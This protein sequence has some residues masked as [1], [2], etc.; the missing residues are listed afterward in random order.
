MRNVMANLL[1]AHY[2]KF[3][4]SLQEASVNYKWISIKIGDFFAAH[5]THIS[6]I[7]DRGNLYSFME[8][9]FVVLNGVEN[10]IQIWDIVMIFC[11]TVNILIL[12]SNGTVNI[13]FA[14]YREYNVSKEN[15]KLSEEMLVF[16]FVSAELVSV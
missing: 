10:Y 14:W 11:V 6:H 12:I 1:F 15:R 2:F 4:L 13:K 16:L 9:F 7:S 5:V 8:I 3:L